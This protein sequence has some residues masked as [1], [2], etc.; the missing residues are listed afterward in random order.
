MKKTVFKSVTICL[1]LLASVEKINAQALTDSIP[2]II[3]LST[4]V[5]SD[6]GLFKSKIKSLTN[7]NYV[8]FCNNHNAFLI[9]IDPTVHGSALAF[10][11]SMIK[12]TGIYK[13]SL[14]EGSVKDIIE[15]CDFNDPS[16]Y[17]KIKLSKNK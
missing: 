9:Y 16:E 10:L 17:E 2:V 5:K 13:L 12:S 1:L 4:D 7:L 8:G 3:S 6:I 15:F 11:G 14:K